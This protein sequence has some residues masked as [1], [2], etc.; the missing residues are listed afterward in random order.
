MTVKNI[1]K[2]LRRTKD[3]FLIYGDGDLIVNGYSDTNFQSDRDNSKSQSDYEFTL[4]DDTISW[5]SSKK[6]MTVA[7]ITESEYIDAFDG[8]LKKQ[9]GQVNS[10][11][12]YKWS[13]TLLIRY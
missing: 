10:F 5:K 13:L 3:V 9:F 12:N 1:L 8:S 7:S 11:M 6:V 2:Y 4:N